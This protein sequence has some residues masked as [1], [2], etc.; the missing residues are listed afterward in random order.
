MENNVEAVLNGMMH[1]MND[2]PHWPDFKGDRR[3]YEN[4]WREY[5]DK[6]NRVN[7]A[8]QILA[9]KSLEEIA[10]QIKEKEHFEEWVGANDTFMN[11]VLD[12]LY[13]DFLSDLV[14]VIHAVD[15]ADIDAGRPDREDW[16][17]LK[18]WLREQFARID[19][20]DVD[21]LIEQQLAQIT[22]PE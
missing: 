9:G 13:P 17:V 16:S 7:A 10:E 22:D 6:Q 18:D 20:V 11:E 12:A 5:H 19:K 3:A 21:K 4:A 1:D 14:K 2:M 8:K 15:E